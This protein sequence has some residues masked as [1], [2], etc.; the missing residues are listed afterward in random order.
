MSMNPDILKKMRE[1]IRKKNVE[2]IK[3]EEEQPANLEKEEKN[4]EEEIDHAFSD[5][6]CKKDIE[7]ITENIE[8]NY[9]SPSEEK[10]QPQPINPILDF[11]FSP[12]SD[13]TAYDLARIL[14][15]LKISISTD[16]YESLPEDLKKHF[17]KFITE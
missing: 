14:N 15:F 2:E 17:T 7:F 5:E 12:K 1:E 3:L 16:I 6:Q 13:I 8:N 11:L 4:P 9:S 10:P